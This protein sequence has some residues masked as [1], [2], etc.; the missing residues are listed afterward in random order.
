MVV[1]GLSNVHSTSAKDSIYGLSG[2]NT[3]SGTD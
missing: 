2:N 3:L 1:R